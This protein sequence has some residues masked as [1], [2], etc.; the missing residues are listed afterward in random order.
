MGDDD[1]YPR[2]VA[3]EAVCGSTLELGQLR[4]DCAFFGWR[5]DGRAATG[6]YD[7]LRRA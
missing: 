2:R 7:L 6:R 1:S 3:G 4:L 5:M